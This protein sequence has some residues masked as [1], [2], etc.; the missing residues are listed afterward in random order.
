MVPC[1]LPEHGPDLPHDRRRVQGVADDVPHRHHDHLAAGPLR[2]GDRDGVEPV[3]ADVLPGVGRLVAGGQGQSVDRRQRGEHRVLQLVRHAHPVV[4]LPGPAE[5]LTGVAGDGRERRQV[6]RVDGVGLR[7]AEHDGPGGLRAPRERDRDHAV[8]AHPAQLLPGLGWVR[9]VELGPVGV[10][11]D[12]SFPNR[13]RRRQRGGQRHHRARR[14]LGVGRPV[15]APG[16]EPH[17]PVVLVEHH[18]ADV[19]RRQ[20]AGDQITD[21]GADVGHAAG[22]GEGLRGQQ[23]ALAAVIGPPLGRLELIPTA[24]LAAGVPADQAQPQVRGAGPSDVAQRVEIGVGPG[25]RPV[26]DSAQRAQDVAVAIGQGHARVGDDA[27]VGRGQV[28]ADRVPAR[29]L[30][31]Q[32]LCRGHD[33]LGERLG[34]RGRPVG[35]PR[36]GAAGHSG[37]NLHLTP[38]Q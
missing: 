27:E 24:P 8:H 15:G 19:D 18:Q 29:V 32:R 20:L 21:P 14:R 7:P 10:V 25:P 31:H 5:G 23:Q 13:G 33:L 2:V 34:Q 30:D 6:R 4:Q 1:G 38:D 12:A 28:V 16:V 9:R 22:V 37:N 11:H 3:P 35:R 17:E 36:F 26:V